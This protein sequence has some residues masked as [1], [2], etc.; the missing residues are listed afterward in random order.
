MT[1][2]ATLFFL[3]MLAHTI[4]VMQLD[5]LLYCPISS[6][7]ASW[8]TCP[9]LSYQ[10][11][12]RFSIFAARD[13]T[14]SYLLSS[15]NPDAYHFYDTASLNTGPILSYQICIRFSIFAARIAAASY[16]LLLSFHHDAYHP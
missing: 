13:A 1:Q 5:S 7:T 4:S 10:I 12:I 3:S 2:L 14:V 6:A 8:N 9:I 16:P 15:F 11:C